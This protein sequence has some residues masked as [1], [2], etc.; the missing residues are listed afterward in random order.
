MEEIEKNFDKDP[1]DLDVVSEESQVED[2]TSDKDYIP[3]EKKGKYEF[4]TFG[5]MNDNMSD[6]YK[7]PRHGVRS[8]RTEYT[9]M[10]NLLSELHMSKHQVERAIV[11]TVNMLFGRE[12]KPYN[13]HQTPDLDTLPSMRNI[14]Q[15]E[16]FFKQ[17]L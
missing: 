16:P 10:S 15:I 6:E 5:K 17:W 13:K 7:H 1:V 4:N 3:E 2:N 9:V 8:V 12:W 14:L 11:T